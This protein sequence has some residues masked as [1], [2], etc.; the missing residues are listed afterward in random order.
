MTIATEQCTTKSTWNEE[1]LDNNLGSKL[2]F[3]TLTKGVPNM[4]TTGC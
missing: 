4:I 2:S 1:M 3:I